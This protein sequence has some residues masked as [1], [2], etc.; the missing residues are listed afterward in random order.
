M[1]VI[2]NYFKRIPCYIFVLTMSFF[3]F[4]SFFCSASYAQTKISSAQGYWKTV[5]DHTH[6]VTSIVAIYSLKD[7]LHAKIVKIYQVDGHH[8]L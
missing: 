7:S 6:H 1:V 5:D 8:M 4:F 3:G 2:M